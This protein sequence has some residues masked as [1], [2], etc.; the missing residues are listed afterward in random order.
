MMSSIITKWIGIFRMTPRLTGL[1]GEHMSLNGT[2]LFKQLGNKL[3]VIWNADSSHQ[4][5]S[6]VLDEHLPGDDREVSL[7]GQKN[8]QLTI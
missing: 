1:K 2:D 5:A 4:G 6:G 7:H 3:W 8:Q